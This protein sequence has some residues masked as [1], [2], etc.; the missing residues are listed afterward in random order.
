M[1]GASTAVGHASVSGPG[2]SYFTVT[3]GQD[4]GTIDFGVDTVQLDRSTAAVPE[5][6]SLALLGLGG[7]TL[8]ARK[9][10][11]A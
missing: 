3:S 5:P 10:R 9:R 8:A 1:S 2:I 7:L 6:S 4:A 11:S